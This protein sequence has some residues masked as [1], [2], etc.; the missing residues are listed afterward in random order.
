M[1][2][3]KFQLLIIVLSPNPREYSHGT[4]CSIVFSRHK[5]ECRYGNVFALAETTR[6][7]FAQNSQGVYEGAMP[8]NTVLRPDGASG[9]PSSSASAS[10][11]TTAPL[12]RGAP[13]SGGSTSSS[14]QLQPRFKVWQP[15]FGPGSPQTPIVDIAR[16]LGGQKNN[17]RSGAQSTSTQG[18][19]E[20]RGS[21]GGESGGSEDLPANSSAALRAG[22]RGG[23]GLPG[24]RSTAEAVADSRGRT[25]RSSLAASGKTRSA[26]D[27]IRG[28]G[29]KPWPGGVVPGRGGGGGGEWEGGDSDDSDDDEEETSDEDDGDDLIL[30]R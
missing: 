26:A 22:A 30:R 19:R 27:V 4:C 23:L 7:L 29:S 17:V 21:R 11:T 20:S 13:S 24:G 8:G 12:H 10:T 14:Q 1:A 28:S 9:T 15:S 16:A 18:H 6:G 3:I 2:Q 5:S 25:G